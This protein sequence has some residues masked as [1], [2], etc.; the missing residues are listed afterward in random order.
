MDNMF[1]STV[2]A[3]SLAAASATPPT[4]QTVDLCFAF[5]HEEVGSKSYNGAAGTFAEDVMR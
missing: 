2:A 4:D 1:G 5:D 3:R